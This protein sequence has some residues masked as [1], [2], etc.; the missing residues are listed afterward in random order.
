[1]NTSH[2]TSQMEECMR[3]HPWFRQALETNRITGPVVNS[4]G[5]EITAKVVETASRCHP[6]YE[7]HK[8]VQ[9]YLGIK[10]LVEGTRRGWLLDQTVNPTPK[11]APSEEMET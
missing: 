2:I 5:I 1:M 11:L 9:S 7:S 4:K 6:G 8:R 10:K 3:D